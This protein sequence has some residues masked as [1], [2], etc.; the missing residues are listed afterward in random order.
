M[1]EDSGSKEQRQDLKKR[2]YDRKRERNSRMRQ[3]LITP[4]NVLFCGCLAYTPDS[5]M[6]SSDIANTQI[7]A[8]R[9]LFGPRVA[10]FQTPSNV[11]RKYTPS[12]YIR[13]LCACASFS[14][15]YFSGISLAGYERVNLDIMA[16][17][18]AR[19]LQDNSLRYIVSFIHFSSL[20]LSLS[21]LAVYLCRH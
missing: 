14:L 7:V 4:Y 21:L 12:H 17:T 19:Y 18:V 6:C 16:T 9:G 1:N 20:S 3:D 15:F 13:W 2:I 10:Y 8:M 5:C 11:S